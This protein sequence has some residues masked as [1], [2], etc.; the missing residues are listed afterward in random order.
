ME[1]LD[2]IEVLIRLVNSFLIL[3][4]HHDVVGQCYVLSSVERDLKGFLLLWTV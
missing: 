4:Q 3:L 2:G 1:V